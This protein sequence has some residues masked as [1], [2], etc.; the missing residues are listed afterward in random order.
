MAV[1]TE[2]VHVKRDDL[3]APAVVVASEH[4]M[5]NGVLR[6]DDV[7][8]LKPEAFT[9]ASTRAMASELEGLN[10]SLVA[11]GR[12]YLLIGFGRWGSS[13]PW[14]GVPVVWGQISG[15]QVIVEATMQKMNP[16]LSQGSHFFHNL[17]GFQIPYLSVPHTGA[18]SIDWGWLESQQTIRETGFVRHVRARAP[19]VIRVDGRNGRGVVLR[20]G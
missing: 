10:R 18:G 16:E 4:A 20:D 2:D 13:D 5:G 11:E 15:A 6:L 3:D 1:S 19:L 7:V 8:F 14:L 17:I 12:R 9:A